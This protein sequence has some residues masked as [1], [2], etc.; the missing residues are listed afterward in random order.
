MP[1]LRGKSPING[2]ILYERKAGVTCHYMNDN[3]DDGDIISQIP[4]DYSE[5]L[6]AGLLYQLSFSAEGDVFEM[7][8]KNSFKTT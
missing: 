6:D 2:A 5:D 8:Y 3:I 1:D 7:A 4:I